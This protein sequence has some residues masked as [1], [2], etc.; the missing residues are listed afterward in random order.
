VVATSFG[1]VFV[2]GQ[3][4]TVYMLDGA[5][6]AVLRAVSAGTGPLAVNNRT[7]RVFVVN[8][9][10][11]G[12]ITIL[13]ARTGARVGTTTIACR[14][15]AGIA[16][17]EHANRVFVACHDS[18]VSIFDGKNGALYKRIAVDVDPVDLA[19]DPQSGR[20]FVI[21][22]YNHPAGADN[23]FTALL[24]DLAY[25]TGHNGGVSVIDTRSGRE[26][27]TARVGHWPAVV[28]VDS[29]EGRA[30][31][32]NSGSHSVTVLNTRAFH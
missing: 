13:D 28:A 8:Q 26:I 17:D 6:G 29:I 22:V 3:A 32:T 1:H 15:P 25:H 9:L 19:V 5:T 20:A 10:N 11:S 16:V 23:L 2:A 31:I 4:G 30:F 12:V 14:V 7:N 27:R 21:G 24:Y 18:T